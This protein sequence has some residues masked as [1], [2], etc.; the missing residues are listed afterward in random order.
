[1]IFYAADAT[2]YL[3]RL[4]CHALGLPYFIDSPRRV[5]MRFILAEIEM[6]SGGLI[7]ADDAAS[8]PP[9]RCPRSPSNSELRFRRLLYERCRCGE[10]AFSRTLLYFKEALMMIIDEL[11]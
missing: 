6:L 8:S 10:L 11:G 1:M 7:Y 4:R 5:S 3:A 9:P 2:S